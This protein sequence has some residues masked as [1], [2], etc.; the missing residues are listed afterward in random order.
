MGQ[1]FYNTINVI[2]NNYNDDASN[3]WKGAPSSAVII[4]RFLEFKGVGVKIA[5]MAANI[6][7]R[8]YKIEMN[9]FS[10]IDISPDVHIKRC[11]YR[12]GLLHKREND[13]FAN[14]SNEEVVYAAKSVN[15]SF[16][17]LM[18]VAFH[19]VGSEGYCRNN[20]CDKDNCYFGKI[21]KRQGFLE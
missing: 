21:C 1:Y 12:L 10:A 6:L 20:K 2:H 13:D 19:K 9:D 16:P 5:N 11:M 18:D 8:E 14:I 15:P 3:I 4:F 7:S 17:G